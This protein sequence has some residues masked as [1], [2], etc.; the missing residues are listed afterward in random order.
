[1]NFQGFS[2]SCSVEGYHNLAKTDKSKN[3]DIVCRKVLAVE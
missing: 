2:F 3:F 1:M